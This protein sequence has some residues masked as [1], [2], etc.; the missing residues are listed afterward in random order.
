M[1]RQ[2]VT[3]DPDT[4][5]EIVA[6]LMVER[7]ISAVPVVDDQGRL[8][9]IVSEG[10]LIRR[11]ELGT[12]RR[13]SWWLA[14]IGDRSQLAEAYIKSHGLLARDVMTTEVVSVDEGTPVA[15]IAELLEQRR[16]K[17][18]PVVRGGMVVGIVSRANLVQAL[19]SLA[20]LDAGAA[21][22]GAIREALLDALGREAWVRPGRINVTVREHVAHIWGSVNSVQEYDALTVLAR[23]TPGVHEV[24]NRVAV[25][26]PEVPMGL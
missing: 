24:R 22:D 3:V 20:S 6:K 5:I 7:G 18:V 23:R 1:T 4:P 19:A 17:R 14:F 25:M 9:G 2:V 8:A 13:R 11:P 21:N 15:A 10:D 16:I 26:P 12:E